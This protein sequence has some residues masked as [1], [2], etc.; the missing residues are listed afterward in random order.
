MGIIVMSKIDMAPEPVIKETYQEVDYLIKK[1]F[2]RMPYKIKSDDDA[3]LCAKK[4]ISGEIVPIFM[5]SN[6]DGRG[7]PQLK[8][9]LNYL[10][11]RRSY[12]HKGK[13]GQN[14]S[15]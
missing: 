11:I 2:R 8:L 13:T 4:M 7:V 9:L 15:S 10:P 3:L 14:A 1:K 5:L 6:V 12:T